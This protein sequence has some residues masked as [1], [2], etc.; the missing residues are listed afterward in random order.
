MPCSL[1][2]CTLAAISQRLLP[3]DGPGRC[4]SILYRRAGVYSL[5]ACPHLTAAA[6]PRRGRAF[7]GPHYIRLPQLSRS[8]N[9][10]RPL[11]THTCLCLR[12]CLRFIRLWAPQP[13]TRHPLVRTAL[14]FGLL[15]ASLD[16][17]YCRTLPSPDLGEELPV[18]QPNQTVCNTFTTP[19]D[20]HLVNVAFLCRTCG[21]RW[22][23]ILLWA[24]YFFRLPRVSACAGLQR[25]AVCCA[26]CGHNAMVQTFFTIL[27]Y[28]CTTTICWTFLWRCN[29]C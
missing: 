6:A 12:L 7:A 5:R 24:P 25:L 4:S 8:I 16:V 22:I 9:R 11:H 13:S 14:L 10:R 21:I 2:A 17:L 27:P 26:W 15:R 29:S 3:H 23:S 18:I 20:S 19:G 1:P 28:R